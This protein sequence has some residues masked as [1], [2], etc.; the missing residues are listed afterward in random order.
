MQRCVLILLL[1]WP[2]L[3]GSPVSAEKP[4]SHPGFKTGFSVGY[5]FQN[6]LGVSYELRVLFTELQ[7]IYPVKQYGNWLFEAVAFPQYNRVWYRYA[8]SQEELANGYELGLNLGIR[9]GWLVGRSGSLLYAGG[10]IGPHYVSGVPQRQA[11]GFL[12]SDNLFAGVNIP[13]GRAF[14]ADLRV[15]FRH[16]SNAGLKRPNGGINNLVVFAG[17]LYTPIH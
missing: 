15:N 9:A 2:V 5:G 4:D 7:L 16:I 8:V 1:F 12:F 10:S 17:L 14:F 6:G 11:P 3:T 13:L